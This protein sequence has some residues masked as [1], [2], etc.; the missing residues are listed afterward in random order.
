M[1]FLMEIIE[2][3]FSQINLLIKILSHN[4]NCTIVYTS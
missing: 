1:K 3:T 4:I 2:L